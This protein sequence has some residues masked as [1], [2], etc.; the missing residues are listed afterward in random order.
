MVKEYTLL[1]FSCI[2]MLTLATT[3]VSST[4]IGEGNQ[5]T[6][7]LQPYKYRSQLYTKVI[8]KAGSNDCHFSELLIEREQI[9]VSS[10]TIVSLIKIL[11]S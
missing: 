2:A 10:S 11:G 6:L 9:T 8:N 3:G 4:K 5:S 7:C 1:G